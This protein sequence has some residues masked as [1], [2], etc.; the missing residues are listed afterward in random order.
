MFFTWSSLA[1]VKIKGFDRSLNVPLHNTQKIQVLTVYYP[2][3][4][5]TK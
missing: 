1:M 5:R 3:I 4:Y 2:P